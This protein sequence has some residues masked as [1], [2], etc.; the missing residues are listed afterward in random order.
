[1]SNITEN[2]ELYEVIRLYQEM[3]PDNDKCWSNPIFWMI[4]VVLATQYLKPFAKA[5]IKKRQ[6]N[7][8]RRNTSTSPV[9]SDV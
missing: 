3:N 6:K 4:L 7:K 1:M 8:E 9:T 5:H 2:S